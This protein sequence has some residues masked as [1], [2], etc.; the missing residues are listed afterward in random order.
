MKH[1]DLPS[2]PTDKNEPLHFS[3][4]G[5]DPSKRGSMQQKRPSE[6]TASGLSNKG[7][8]NTVIAISAITCL[9]MGVIGYELLSNNHEKSY[10]Q[11]SRLSTTGQHLFVDDLADEAEEKALKLKSLKKENKWQAAQ[12][13]VLRQELA[14]KLQ[15]IHEVKAELFKQDGDPRDKEKITELTQSL[16]DKELQYQDLLFKT[17]TAENHSAELERKIGQLEVTRDALVGIIENHRTNKEQEHAAL[18]QKIETLQT[19]SE[20]EKDALSSKIHELE[21]AHEQLSESLEDKKEQINTLQIDLAQQQAELQGK[22]LDFESLSQ[23]YNETQE[24][25]KGDILDLVSNLQ[26]EITSKALA[27]KQALKTFAEK[28]QAIETLKQEIAENHQIAIHQAMLFD[29]LEEL[30]TSDIVNLVSSLETENILAHKLTAEVKTIA[31]EK[32]Q[33]QLDYAEQ[34]R[35]LKTEFD[36]QTAE[37]WDHNESLQTLVDAYLQANQELH[38]QLSMVV[39]SHEIEMTNAAILKLKLNELREQLQA[40]EEEHS[41]LKHISSAAKASNSVLSE[42][43]SQQELLLADLQMQLDSVVDI[44]YENHDKALAQTD[45]LIR[46]LESK[47]YELEQA[48]QELELLRE[49]Y[50]DT[51]QHLSMLAGQLDQNTLQL[52]DLDDSLITAQWQLASQDSLLKELQQ[53]TIHEDEFAVYVNALQQQITSKEL[54]ILATEQQLDE[55]QQELHKSLADQEMLLLYSQQDN[56]TLEESYHELLI[57]YDNNQHQL[58]DLEQELSKLSW[59]LHDAMTLH[60]EKQTQLNEYENTLQT[61]E[62]KLSEKEE[63]A[64][65]LQKQLDFAFEQQQKLAADNELLQSQNQLHEQQNHLIN[66][67]AAQTEAELQSLLLTLQNEKQADHVRHDNVLQALDRKLSEKEELAA[68]LQSQLDFAFEQLTILATDKNEQH[69]NRIQA[70]DHQL[71]EKEEQAADL[72]SQ[73]DFAFEQL[74]RLSVEKEQ[75]LLQIQVHEQQNS[76]QYENASRKETEL[77]TMLLALQNEIQADL[78]QHENML[79]ALDHQL[80]EKDER[81]DNTLK[82][83]ERLH[84]EKEEQITSLQIQLNAAFDQL[85]QLTTENEQLHLQKEQ[86]ELQ[87]SHLDQ[88]TQQQE[89]AL[90][91]R[92]LQLVDAEHTRDEALREME[93]QQQKIENLEL[94]LQSAALKASILKEELNVHKAKLAQQ[95]QQQLQQSVEDDLDL[96]DPIAFDDV[97]E[98]LFNWDY[99]DNDDF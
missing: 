8:K 82:A 66:E 89:A 75:L 47:T 22:I 84:S 30:T 21:A 44:Y 74:T 76:L 3:N 46:A 25:I 4:I 11:A 71:S 41:Y 12:I 49:Q 24:A 87:R 50:S 14:E 36:Q 45:N 85:A 19:S 97:N 1:D 94:Q 65:D 99:L 53:Q 18:K 55:V 32:Q 51:Q 10:V 79:Q 58:K 81:H 38:A 31:Q 68:D 33:A 9:F 37:Q 72:Q 48:Q 70:L 96:S 92:L 64:D 59:E 6:M 35:D 67:H 56:S 43:Y 61:F 77:Q 39:A 16:T 54:A 7:K 2:E 13:K 57:L 52:G 42:Q 73:I 95:Q 86:Q 93:Q 20:T 62:S 80:S 91:H 60:S 88:D 5:R 29:H 90:Q 28:S 27:E 15:S 26:F 98:E 63:L 17:K 40:L 78:E 34:L 69:E 83:V 23:Q